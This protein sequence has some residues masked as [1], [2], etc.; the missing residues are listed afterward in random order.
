MKNGTYRYDLN[1]QTPLGRRR[2]KLELI[3][4]KNWINGCLTMFTRTVPIRSSVLTGNQ[5][6]FEG[7]MITVMNRLPYKAKG[8][9]S[10]SGVE[11][12]LTTPKGEYPVLGTLVEGKD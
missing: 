1:M 2:G 10:V 7:E 4:E 3:I 5:I 8:T 11:L 12:T 9:V 6:S